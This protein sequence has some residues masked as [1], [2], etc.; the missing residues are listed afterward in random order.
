M[1]KPQDIFAI[2]DI[3]PKIKIWSCLKTLDFAFP[4]ADNSHGWGFHSADADSSLHPMWLKGNCD[5]PCG[6]QI[7][8]LVTLCARHSSGVKWPIMRIGFQGLE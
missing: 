2:T 3:N 6:R 1:L 8:D 4:C 7:G 5:C